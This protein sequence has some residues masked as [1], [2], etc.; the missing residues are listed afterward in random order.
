MT[1]SEKDADRDRNVA[2]IR[3]LF[4]KA[5]GSSKGNAGSPAWPPDPSSPLL[6]IAK[7]AYR[8]VHGSEAEVRAIHGGLE[9]G[10]FRPVFPRWDMISIGPTIRYPLSPD[11]A[12][13]IASVE[14]FWKLLLEIAARI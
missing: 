8:E 6:A 10:L 3:G 9:T 13:D 7:K 2:A 11:E 4:E 12:V 14:R 1:R 5:G